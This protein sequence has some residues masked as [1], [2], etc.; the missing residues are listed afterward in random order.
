[1]N[2]YIWI[3]IWIHVTYEFIWFLHI[4]IHMFHEFIYEFG[5]TKVPDVEYIW[6]TLKRCADASVIQVTVKFC[7]HNIIVNEI[8]REH[9]H[10]G[11]LRGDARSAAYVWRHYKYASVSVARLVLSESLW[12]LGTWTYGMFCAD[13][14]VRVPVYSCVQVCVHQDS[15]ENNP[16]KCRAGRTRGFVQ[17]LRILIPDW[18][19]AHF[20][21]A[22][23]ERWMS[24]VGNCAHRYIG[25]VCL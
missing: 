2:S 8:V 13:A 5:Y 24:R 16:V 11:S 7:K 10:A 17:I 18:V 15:G 9:V 14:N 6:L 21:H 23:D 22:A 12:D 20:V 1:M 19:W 4:W 25:K 3:H